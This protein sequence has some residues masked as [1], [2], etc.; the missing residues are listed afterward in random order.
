MHGGT[1]L[2][3]G[4]GSK[5]LPRSGPPAVKRAFANTAWFQG[6]HERAC[7]E[8]TLAQTTPRADGL[9]PVFSLREQAQLPVGER[10]AARKGLAG[11]VF[12]RDT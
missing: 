8:S 10:F 12:S 4:G 6:F 3:S 5:A 9:Q 1:I 2:P 7:T 11:L